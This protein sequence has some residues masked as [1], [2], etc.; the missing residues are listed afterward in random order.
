MSSSFPYF[1]SPPAHVI[2]DCP[3]AEINALQKAGIIKELRMSCLDKNIDSQQKVNLVLNNGCSIYSF[4]SSMAKDITAISNGN[5][6]YFKEREHDLMTGEIGA[7]LTRLG[8]F[9][10]PLP[11]EHA[12]DIWFYKRCPIVNG[13]ANEA[14]AEEITEDLYT[15]VF[16]DLHPSIKDLLSTR[17]LIN[18]EP[19]LITFPPTAPQLT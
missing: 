11:P 1:T 2:S 15:N 17:E 16:N 4:R 3:E 14:A 19:Q 12:P 6:F 8:V 9:N 13:W 7:L 18:W 5:Y 10:N